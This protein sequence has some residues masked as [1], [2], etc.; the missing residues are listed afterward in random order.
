M[1]P[2]KRDLT[3]H[4][5]SAGHRQG[6]LPH[7]PYSKPPL[8][9]S[10]HQED[11]GGYSLSHQSYQSM[12]HRYPTQAARGGGVLCQLLDPAND[13]SFSVTSL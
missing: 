12:S 1:P 2:H 5:M 11:T 13:D 7:S 3:P 10:P 4:S 9:S 8:D 6:P